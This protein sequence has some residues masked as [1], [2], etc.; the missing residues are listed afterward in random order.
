MSNSKDLFKIALNR[1]F[2]RADV[3]IGGLNQG[4]EVIPEK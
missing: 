3:R 2:G 1:P 4:V